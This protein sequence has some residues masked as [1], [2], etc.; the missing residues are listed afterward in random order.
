MFVTRGVIARAVAAGL[1]AGLVLTATM[2]A[3]RLQLNA[4]SFPERIDDVV[5]L[6]MPQELFSEVLERLRFAA[7]PLLFVGIVLAQLLLAAIGGVIYGLAAVALAGRVDFTHPFFG[8]AVG[9]F[10]SIAL[11]LLILPALGADAPLVAAGWSR[12]APALALTVGPGLAYGVSLAL[13]LRL[14]SPARRSRDPR[15]GGY[16]APRRRVTRR[17]ILA[18]LI[19][20]AGAIVT[21]VSLRALLGGAR[22]R[23]AVGAMQGIPSPA[24]TSAAAAPPT[25]SPAAANN[26][27]IATTAA[28]AMPSA[29]PVPMRPGTS[30]VVSSPVVAASSPTATT[31]PTVPPTGTPLPTPIPGGPTIPAGVAAPITPVGRFYTISKN[32]LDPLLLG[33]QWELAITGLVAQPRTIQLADLQRLPGVSQPTTLTCISNEVGG[34]LI[35]TAIW[36]G[37]PLATLLA[38]AGVQPSATHLIFSCEDGYTEVLPLDRALD[39][40]TLLVY[41]MNGAPLSER[42]GY[43]ARLIAPGRYGMKNPKWITGIEAANRPPVGYWTQRGWS[44]D[45][46]IQTSVRIDAPPA[47]A[48]V[49]PGPTE[50]GGIAFAGDRGISRVEISVDGGTTWRVAELEA[51]LGAATWV[52]WVAPWHPTRPGNQVILARAYDGDGTPQTAT[53]RKAGPGGATGYA[54]RTVAIAP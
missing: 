6:A 23:Q 51:P 22:P 35:G 33:Q 52:R 54:R 10:T 48:T 39:P 49:P 8:G 29:T 31:T 5:L 42:H 19:P 15:T 17:A 26:T 4:P 40:A 9:V 50:V 30:P 43:P 37:M 27:P 2:L 34:D 14:L 28:T 7:K 46:P 16:D 12:A 47:E 3:L 45:E 38:S 53:E 20:A 11:D 36:T 1:G 21:A 24:A 32:F 41:A 25:M 13:L 18:L 44:P